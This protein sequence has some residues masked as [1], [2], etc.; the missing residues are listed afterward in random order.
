MKKTIEFV[1]KEIVKDDKYS[2]TTKM[3]YC[4][5]LINSKVEAYK[6][7]NTGGVFV[8]YYN[9]YLFEI[10]LYDIYLDINFEGKL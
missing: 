1:S 7:L 6:I 3:Y 2:K 4:K 9:D 10:C 8:Q 5:R